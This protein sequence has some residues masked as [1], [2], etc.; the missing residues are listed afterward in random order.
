M[1]YIV[2]TPDSEGHPVSDKTRVG[3]DGDI[4]RRIIAI[5]VPLDGR[6]MHMN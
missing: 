6:Y 3:G 5:C 2:T 1:H 4:C